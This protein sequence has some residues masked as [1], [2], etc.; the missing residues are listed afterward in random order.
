MLSSFLWCMAALPLKHPT[1]PDLL[2]K[3]PWNGTNGITCEALKD[4]KAVHYS[5]MCRTEKPAV[6]EASLKQGMASLL[7]KWSRFMRYLSQLQTTFSPL[8][9]LCYL[10]LPSGCLFIAVVFQDR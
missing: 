10:A 9:S 6:N 8:S 5:C 1:A 2:C 4:A 7:Q 3:S